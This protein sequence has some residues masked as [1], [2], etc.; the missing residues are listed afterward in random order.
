MA[1][2][3]LIV[4]VAVMVLNLIAGVWGTALWFAHRPSIR[5][6]YAVRAAQGSVIL[7]V[8]LG[9]VLLLAG[10]EAKDAIHYMYGAA[11]L[12]INFFAEGM[13]IGAAQREVG[14]RDFRSLDQGEQRKIGLRIVRRETGIMA[15]AC[16]LIVAF[17]VRAAQVSGKMF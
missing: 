1:E 2:V 17:S 8:L 14:A 13:R 15:A 6:W 7:Q 3:H 9:A 10:R 5:Y 11:P 12:L 4:G 16:L